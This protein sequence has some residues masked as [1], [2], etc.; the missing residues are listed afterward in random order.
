M[1]GLSLVTVL[2][3]GNPFYCVQGIFIEFPLSKVI[4]ILWHCSLVRYFPIFKNMRS[5]M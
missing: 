5:L 2:L 3:W 1:G 4:E